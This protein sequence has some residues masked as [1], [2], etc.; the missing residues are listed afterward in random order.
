[1]TRG[2]Y[3]KL[4]PEIIHPLLFQVLTA[5]AS[6][7]SAWGVGLEQDEAWAPG[8]AVALCATGIR[9]AKEGSFPSH[10]PSRAVR[11]PRV[12]RAGPGWKGGGTAFVWGLK[13]R[14]RGCFYPPR[15]PCVCRGN[16]IRLLPSADKS[17]NSFLLACV[18]SAFA[19]IG[20]SGKE[21]CKRRFCRLFSPH[22][23]CVISEGPAETRFRKALLLERGLLLV[24]SGPENP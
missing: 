24:S 17:E 13:R 11:P 12:T 6:G 21:R 7:D 16:L 15:L 20:V 18:C 8:G 22:R 9:D 2:V 23:I 4:W 1:M 5:R 3:L 14:N 19:V 10:L